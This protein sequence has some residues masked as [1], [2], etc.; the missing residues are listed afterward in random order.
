MDSSASTYKVGQVGQL[1]LKTLLEPLE[2][3]AATHRHDVVVQLSMVVGRTTIHTTPRRRR[4]RRTCP[5]SQ[6]AEVS[7]RCPTRGGVGTDTREWHIAHHPRRSRCGDRVARNT[8]AP[9]GR[10]KDVWGMV[11]CR[12]SSSG[13]S[14]IDPLAIGTQ[15]STYVCSFNSRPTKLW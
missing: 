3:G 5:S 4:E 8:S 10:V 9:S 2:A 11:R 6:T 15:A 13:F 14:E 7:E 1:Q 12:A